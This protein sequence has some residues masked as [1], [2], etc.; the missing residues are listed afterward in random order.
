MSFGDV[1]PNGG[2][3]RLKLMGAL[4]DANV[5]T[6]RTR[7]LTAGKASSREVLSRLNLAIAGKQRRHL[8]AN[9]AASMRRL[10]TGPGGSLG[11]SMWALSQS[12]ARSKC[13]RLIAPCRPCRASG[14]P[15]DASTAGGVVAGAQQCEANGEDD[16]Y[17]VRR[18][19]QLRIEGARDPRIPIHAMANPL[20]P[21]YYVERLTQRVERGVRRIDAPG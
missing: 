18:H 4:L 14:G 5:E 13:N 8:G 17:R 15:L 19:A 16:G 9:Q 20:A 1:L 6:R 11:L 10:R 21:T 7:A 3:A 12:V 2:V